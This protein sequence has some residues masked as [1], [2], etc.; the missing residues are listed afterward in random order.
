MSM[1]CHDQKKGGLSSDKYSI[2]TTWILLRFKAMAPYVGWAKR[3]KKSG[4]FDTCFLSVKE[5][6]T[7]GA[8]VHLECM[9]KI[10]SPLG[11]KQLRD[12]FIAAY[13]KYM[14]KQ[15]FFFLQ[16]MLNTV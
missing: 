13:E 4:F 5:Y 8:L 1:I 14:I 16:C 6:P 11:P 3:T 7:R 10:R 12:Y 15:R 2:P 9:K